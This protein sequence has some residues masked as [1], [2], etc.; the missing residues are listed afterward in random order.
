MSNK[1]NAMEVVRMQIR[2]GMTKRRHLLETKPYGYRLKV[3][4]CDVNDGLLRNKYCH[5][6]EHGL[7]GGE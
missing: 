4:E 1:D 5:I 7:K 2:S 6:M 3:A